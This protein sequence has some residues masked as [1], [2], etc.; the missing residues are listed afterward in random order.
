MS[1]NSLLKIYLALL[2]ELFFSACSV[3]PKPFSMPETLFQSQQDIHTLEGVRVSLPQKIS[4]N[5]AIARALKYNLDYRVQVVEQAIAE[6][7]RSLTSMN[8]LPNLVATAGYVDRSNINAV[9][10]PVTGQ[11][12]T[13]EDRVRQLADLK[14]SWNLL[15]FGVSYFESKQKADQVL[16]AAEKKRKTMQRLARDTRKAF[17]RA[18]AVAHYHQLAKN[19]HNELK[20]TL[21]KAQ[22]AQ[23]KKLMPPLDAARYQRDMWLLYNQI[24]SIQLELSRFFPELMSLMSAPSHS[25][26]QLISSREDKYDLSKILPENINDLE[27]LALFYR[28]EI[29]Q[30]R[31]NKRI[32]LNE[33]YKARVRLVPGL[34][35][36]DGASYD[37]NSYLVNKTWNQLSLSLT[38]NIIKII[39]NLKN[40]Q[41]AKQQGFLVE[42]RR[43]ALAMAIVSQVDIAKI[44]YNYA[45]ENLLSADGVLNSERFVY[46]I[47]INQNNSFESQ[48]SIA[49]AHGAYM[50]AQLRR[51]LAYADYQAAVGD[52]L[53][54]IGIDPLLAPELIALPLPELTKHLIY[55]QHNQLAMKQN[56][57][58]TLK[59][60]RTPM[61]SNK[62]K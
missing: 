15:D 13:A 16:V 12:S 19:Y 11:V 54:S 39:A 53:D 60:L 3:R 25:R 51:D 61:V 62:G 57:L 6:T 30:E 4:V 26:V 42:V 36:N 48:F 22:Q 33:V 40:L 41:L 47:L 24:T 17:W 27:E 37:S 49:R 8:M 9:L 1:W 45:K 52:L 43:I 44:T 38:W 5:H 23:E 28:P 32:A 29:A 55:T 35:I 31:Y 2:I 59:E 21:K 14:F 34:E 56:I 20:S 50:L 46:K 58:N 18:Y 7:D 10:S